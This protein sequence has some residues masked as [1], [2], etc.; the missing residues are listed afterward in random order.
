V[1]DLESEIKDA[2]NKVL[3]LRKQLTNA[4]EAHDLQL[5]RAVGILQKKVQ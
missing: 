3:D 1:K 5:D 4:V 2:Q